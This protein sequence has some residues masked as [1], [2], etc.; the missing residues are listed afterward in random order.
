MRRRTFLAGA[1]ATGAVGAGLVPATALADPAA[2]DAAA[3]MGSIP[4]ATG[5]DDLTIPGS[6]DSCARIGGPFDTAKCQELTLPQQFDAGVRFIDI[7]CRL[8]EG[9]F[10]IHHGP[11]YQEKNFSDVLGD[12]R[13]LFGAHPSETVIMSVQQEYSEASAQDWA[14]V[15][16]DRYMRDEG[17]DAMFLRDNRLPSL[18][19][20]RGKVVLIANQDFIGGIPASNA[21]L[22]SYQNDWEAPADAKWDLVRRHLDDAEADSSSSKLYVNYSSTTAG[23]TIPQPRGYAEELNPKIK[24]YV[25][26]AAGRRPRYGAVVMDFA[27]S[28]E[29]GL[30]DSLIACN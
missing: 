17:F 3:W 8:Y 24:T 26:A 10:T 22:L 4:D 18:G 9:A 16:N 19:E 12:C 6:H 23:A 2:R 27:A 15:F 28:V 13:A 25:D 14:A 11:I 29:P 21:D 1:L 7:R 30:V 5:L 20:A